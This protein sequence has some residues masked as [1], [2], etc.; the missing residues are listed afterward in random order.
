M[1]PY[2]KEIRDR[3]NTIAGVYNG[4]E[5]S[6]EEILNIIFGITEAAGIILGDKRIWYA[7]YEEYEERFEA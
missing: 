1:K 4:T 5:R 6:K 7:I 3:C 2:E